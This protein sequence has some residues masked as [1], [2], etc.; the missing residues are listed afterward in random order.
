M[1]LLEKAT[2]VINGNAD[3]VIRDSN[4]MDCVVS[5]SSNCLLLSKEYGRMC[6]NSKH[7]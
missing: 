5:N 3:E 4:S 7:W 1:N 2:I 6:L